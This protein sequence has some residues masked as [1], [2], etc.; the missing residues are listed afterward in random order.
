MPMLLGMPAFAPLMTSM[1]RPVALASLMGHVLF[2]V[3]LGVT[4]V[5]LRGTAADARVGTARHA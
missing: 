5:A 4:F 1:M 3:I 2:G